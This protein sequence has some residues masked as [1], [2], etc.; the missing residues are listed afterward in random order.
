MWIDGEEVVAPIPVIAVR[1]VLPNDR[2]DPNRVEAHALDI[3]ES[4]RQSGKIAP[5]PSRS[6]G[7]VDRVVVAR[8]AI[9]EAISD[10]EVDRSSE[11]FVHRD[12]TRFAGQRLGAKVI[13]ATR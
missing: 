5:V 13:L 2:R 9:L 6:I 10:D 8:V 11:P 7:Q 12:G 1:V 3:V 4:R